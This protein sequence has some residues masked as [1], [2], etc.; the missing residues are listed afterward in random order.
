[1]NSVFGTEIGNFKQV[2]NVAGKQLDPIL[3]E[4]KAGQ[5]VPYEPN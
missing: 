5:V 4:S 2:V 1:M 3:E